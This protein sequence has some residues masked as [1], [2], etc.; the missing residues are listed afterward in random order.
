MRVSIGKSEVDVDVDGT[1]AAYAK[2]SVPRPESCGCGYC[3]NWAA[4]RGTT[5][6]EGVK[7]LL[8]SMGIKPGYETEVW[9]ISWE[10]G[11]HFYCGW[12]TFI[13]S[14]SAKSDERAEI[15]GMELWVSEGSRV[16]WLPWEGASEIHFSTV[17]GWTIEEPEPPGTP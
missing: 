5:Y 11:R 15:G 10:S 17:I 3:R 1:R 2:L 13:G 14:V 4:Q 7:K 6:P 9:A 16:P 12:Y 8:E